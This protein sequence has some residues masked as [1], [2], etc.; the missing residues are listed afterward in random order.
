M[1]QLEC[2]VMSVHHV[3]MSKF[4][5]IRGPS[6]SSATLVENQGNRGHCGPC[7]RAFCVLFAFNCGLVDAGPLK[8]RRPFSWPFLEPRHAVV[9]RFS[10][11]HRW[12]CA[13][14]FNCSALAGCTGGPPPL[15]ATYPGCHLTRMPPPLLQTAVSTAHRMHCDL[16]RATG[17]TMEVGVRVSSPLFLCGYA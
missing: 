13:L 9:S 12:H 7:Y 10:Y 3:H 15:D 14:A 11:S 5:M 16:A 4:K 17:G 8:E 1:S 6:V 2:P